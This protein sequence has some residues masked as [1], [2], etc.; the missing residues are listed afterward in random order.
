M[1]R[2]CI[3]GGIIEEP[4]CLPHIDVM[5]LSFTDCLQ[6]LSLAE[7]RIE[8]QEADRPP[9]ERRDPRPGIA[10]RA[11]LVLVGGQDI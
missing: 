5:D 9:A 2:L 4:A 11:A 7:I 10:A 8:R 6:R 1:S 3:H